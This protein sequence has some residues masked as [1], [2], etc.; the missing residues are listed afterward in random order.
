[1]GSF[2]RLLSGTMLLL[3]LIGLVLVNLSV[4]ANWNYWQIWYFI[5]RDGLFI[6]GGPVG[7]GGLGFLA[8]LYLASFPSSRA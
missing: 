3:S 4:V 5:R 6:P 2:M 8:S 1:M 7:I